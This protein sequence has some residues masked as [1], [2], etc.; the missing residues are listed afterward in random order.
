MPTG[1]FLLP[2]GSY[3]TPKA[4]EKCGKEAPENKKGTTKDKKEAH[5]LC[6]GTTKPVL[7]VKTGEKWGDFEKS[8]QIWK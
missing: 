2:K 6:L 5:K 4:G 3:Q 7:G 8:P 1:G